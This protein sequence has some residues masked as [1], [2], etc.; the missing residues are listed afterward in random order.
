MATK[1][2]EPLKVAYLPRMV[3]LKI[4]TQSQGI[5]KMFGIWAR[6]WALSR[7]V[8]LEFND[9]DKTAIKTYAFLFDDQT[10]IY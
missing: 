5:V 3:R 4:E 9:A 6:E 2:A 1:E 10:K 8:R 7:K